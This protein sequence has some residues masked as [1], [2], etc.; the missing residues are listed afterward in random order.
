MK[1]LFAAA[2]L[3]LATRGFAAYEIGESIPNLCWQNV[4]EQTVCLDDFKDTVRVL[5]FNAGWC[6]PC[7]TGMKELAAKAS[8]FAG[9][10]VT[11][12]SLSINGWTHG[13]QPN[14]QFLK[15]WKQ[16]HNIPFQ[17]VGTKGQQLKDFFPAPNYIPSIAVIDRAGKLAYR[18][19]NPSVDALFA[20]VRRLVGV[21]PEPIPQP[22]PFPE[23]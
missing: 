9:Q 14:T 22:I 16:K 15:E 3:L 21:A 1:R 2:V 20:E 23:P 17:V 10:P 5:D 11:F 4:D 18:E 6:P 8:E 7:N 12:L 13:S 19:V